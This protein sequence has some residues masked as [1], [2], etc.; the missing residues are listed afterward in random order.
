[1][2][3]FLFNSLKNI[4]TLT[5]NYGSSKK[6]NVDILAIYSK[7]TLLDLETNP[8]LSDPLRGKTDPDPNQN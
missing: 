7:L 8:G 5:V 6:I 2:L 3:L 4:I 1:M